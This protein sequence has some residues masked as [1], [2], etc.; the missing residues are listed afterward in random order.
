MCSG[1]VVWSLRMR[2]RL[3]RNS[4]GDG[5]VSWVGAGVVE[6][7][8]AVVR[9]GSVDRPVWYVGSGMVVELG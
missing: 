1:V 6:L 9:D 5:G 7:R 2:L 3:S 4:G 8:R